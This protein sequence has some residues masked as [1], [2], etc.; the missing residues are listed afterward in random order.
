[1]TTSLTINPSKATNGAGTDAAGVLD[2][3][4]AVA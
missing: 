4:K 3:M 1:M 2:L